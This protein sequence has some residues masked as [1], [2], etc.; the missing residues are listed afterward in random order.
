MVS[1]HIGTFKIIILKVFIPSGK[2][3][4]FINFSNVTSKWRLNHLTTN[5]RFSSVSN[6]LAIMKYPIYD[7]NYDNMKHC[8]ALNEI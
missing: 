3:A 6:G 5:P 2:Y 1:F 4:I 8:L 7:P